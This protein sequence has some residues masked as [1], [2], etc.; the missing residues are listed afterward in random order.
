[1][2]PLSIFVSVGIEQTPPP[3]STAHC[4]RPGSTQNNSGAAPPAACRQKLPLGLTIP[5]W[6]LCV[7][8]VLACA[9]GECMRYP[10][11]RSQ[12][13]TVGSFSWILPQICMWLHLPFSHPCTVQKQQLQHLQPIVCG[14]WLLLSP[15]SFLS[16]RPAVKVWWS[17]CSFFTLHEWVFI[18]GSYKWLL[19]KGKT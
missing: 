2:F 9:V 12:F 19:C 15:S 1:M 4:L 18:H 17:F 8:F 11:R 3:K 14:C 7:C 13:Y 6:A 10:A 16:A 5:L